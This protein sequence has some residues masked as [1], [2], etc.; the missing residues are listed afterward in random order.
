MLILIL[1]T[2]VKDHKQLEY[3]IIKQ[4]NKWN[5]LQTSK[6]FKEMINNKQ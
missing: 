6:S 1:K 5:N 2:K 3:I 4:E